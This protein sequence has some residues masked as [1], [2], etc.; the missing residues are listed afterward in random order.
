MPHVVLKDQQNIETTYEN[1]NTISLNSAD[2][3]LVTYV[4]EHLI[5]NQVQANWAQTNPNEPDYI[6][7]KP[8]SELPD[9]SSVDNEK[10]LQVVNGAW[11]AR[12]PKSGLPDVATDDNEKILQ[13]KNG[14]WVV[15]NVAFPVPLTQER[16]NA[17]ENHG[18]V[19]YLIVSDDV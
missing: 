5:Q 15:T 17:I 8:D 6:K 11:E 4:S 12:M 9:V 3:G 13:V 7:N 18:D 1:I 19:I 10:V 2:G 16:Y 14:V